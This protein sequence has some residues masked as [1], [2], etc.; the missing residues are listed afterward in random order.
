MIRRLI[1]PLLDRWDWADGLGNFYK[2]V[3]GVILRP[4]ILRDFLHGTWLGH[5]LHPLL[6]DVPIGALTV[7][8]ILDLLGIVDGANWATLIGFAG[9]IAAAF[10]GFADYQYTEGKSHRYGAI[11]ASFMLLAIAFY[12]FSLAVRYGYTA[13][14]AYHA[15]VTAALGYAMLSLGAYIGGELVFTLGNQVD[16]HAWRGGGEKWTPIEAPELAE[17]TPTKVKAGAQTLVLVRTG[18]TIQALHDTCSHRGCSLADGKLVGN[19][20]EC[21]CHGSQFDLASGHVVH[22]PAVADQPRYEVRRIDGKLEVRRT[23]PASG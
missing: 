10:A 2:T 13:G 9:L 22:G 6:T 11:H 17:G 5:P 20:V 19:A 3:D 16:R 8:L 7:A 18:D 12:L 15:T 23:T 4:R 21:P 1:N 14:T